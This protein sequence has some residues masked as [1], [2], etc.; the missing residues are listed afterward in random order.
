MTDTF[1][2]YL[3]NYDFFIVLCKIGKVRIGL[4]HYYFRTNIRIVSQRE[5]QFKKLLPTQARTSFNCSDRQMHSFC[6]KI[7]TNIP[8][9]FSLIFPRDLDKKRLDRRTK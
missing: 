2:F 6:M 5:E 1:V 7:T 8:N 4:T 9:N 3:F